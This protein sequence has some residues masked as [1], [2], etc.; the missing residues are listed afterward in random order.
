MQ[1]APYVNTGQVDGFL[2]PQVISASETLLLL[3]VDGGQEWR[4]GENKVIFVL[5]I[6]G[7]LPIMPVSPLSHPPKPLKGRATK[8]Q[9]FL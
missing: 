8:E 9:R 2:V 6:S 5:G 3:P 4:W 1:A 7:S